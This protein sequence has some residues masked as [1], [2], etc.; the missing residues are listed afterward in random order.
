MLPV[1]QSL[2]IISSKV[3]I[4]VKFLLGVML[5]SY[6]VITYVFTVICA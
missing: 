5:F 3:S 6:G 2:F 4:N 1:I